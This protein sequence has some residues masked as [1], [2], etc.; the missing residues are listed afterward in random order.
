MR[1]PTYG[2]LEARVR[3][4]LDLQDTDNFV[5]NDEMASYANE[6]IN[7]AEAEIM[8]LHEDYFLTKVPI[9]FVQ[10]EDEIVLPDNIYA[11]KIREFIYINGPRIYNIFRMRD[12]QKFYQRALLNQY[13]TSVTEYWYMLMSNT[14]GEQDTIKLAP[15]AQE[16]GQFAELWYI[17]NA[18]RVPLST[19]PGI[20][21]SQQLATVIDIP[22]W[23][24]YIVQ[25][26][27]VRCMA[28]EM[29]PRLDAETAALLNRKKVLVE[30]LQ[31][32]TPDNQDTV[33]MD[34]TFYWEHN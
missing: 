27:K 24:D 4:D 19:E 32:R 20:T 8:A 22:E 1:L 18:N 16:S 13:P 34:T 29:D 23:S 14:A 5:L 30:T 9:T 15:P 26:M 11:Q 10:G 2:E 21:R 6:G 28:K 33:P 3:R 12:P 25:F 17:R 31:N 7:D